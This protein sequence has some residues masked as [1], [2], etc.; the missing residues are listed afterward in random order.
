MLF[1]KQP[2]SHGDWRGLA[3]GGLWIS[4]ISSQPHI[5]HLD[6]Q[7][8]GTKKQKSK[9]PRDLTLVEPHKYCVLTIH[10]TILAEKGPLF[11][12]AKKISDGQDPDP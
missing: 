10:Y 12:N 4:L 6:E 8:R 11:E 2:L 5:L 3:E 1:A 9:L 7:S